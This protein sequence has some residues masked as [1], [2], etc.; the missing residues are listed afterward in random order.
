M[1]TIAYFHGP[2]KTLQYKAGYKHGQKLYNG[3]LF[4]VIEKILKSK[5][6]VMITQKSNSKPP[7]IE[8]TIWIDNGYFKQK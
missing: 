2:N 6:N 4:P 5:L 7:Y 8:Y 1:I 3:S